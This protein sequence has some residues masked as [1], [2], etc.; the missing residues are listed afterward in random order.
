MTLDD[1]VIKCVR[2]LGCFVY[3]FHRAAS[4]GLFG[5][6]L[7]WYLGGGGGVEQT[8]NMCFEIYIYYKVLYNDVYNNKMHNVYGKCFN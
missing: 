7:G 6:V 2:I 5:C 1:D 8:Q 4:W 3:E